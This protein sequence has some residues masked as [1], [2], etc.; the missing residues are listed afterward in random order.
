MNNGQQ[1]NPVYVAMSL[2][3]PLVERLI[4]ESEREQLRIYLGAEESVRQ[5]KLAK[6]L[7]QKDKRVRKSKRRRNVP[8]WESLLMIVKEL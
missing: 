7:S 6:K 4:L 8:K 3:W 1:S 2:P 5:Q